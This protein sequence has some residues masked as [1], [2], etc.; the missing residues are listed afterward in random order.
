[1]IRIKKGD[2]WKTAFRSQLG[3]YKYLIM[4]FRLTNA[5][6]TLQDRVDSELREYINIY[7]DPYI[8]DILI[9]S[10]EYEEHIQHVH[11]ILQKL[12]NTDLIVVP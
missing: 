6:V 8:D 1:M 7:T 2:K 9:Y 12:E 5:P 4:P 3:L 10:D 11:L